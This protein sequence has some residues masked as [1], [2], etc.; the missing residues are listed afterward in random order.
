MARCGSAAS[1]EAFTASGDKFRVEGGGEMT[2]FLEFFS[3]RE[4]W[5]LLFAGEN[6]LFRV[7]GFDELIARGLR[8][9]GD[10]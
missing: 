8:E 6:K 2:R 4:T 10:K 3:H 9:R 1:I 5:V 7:R